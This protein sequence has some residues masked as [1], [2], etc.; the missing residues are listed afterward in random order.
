[1]P[2]SSAA[3]HTIDIITQTRLGNEA[4]GKKCMWERYSVASIVNK[5]EGD[6]QYVQV[7]VSLTAMGS[8]AR[9]RNVFKTWKQ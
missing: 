2:H 9:A 7:A 6:V 4:S 8:E 5:E 1:M 3:P